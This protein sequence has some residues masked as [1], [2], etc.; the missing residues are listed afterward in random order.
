LF[1][2]LGKRKAFTAGWPGDEVGGD[3]AQK[4]NE[5]DVGEA[6]TQAATVN[7]VSVKS[8]EY[9]MSGSRAVHTMSL[10]CVN[11]NGRGS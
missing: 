4:R 7:V 8:G 3:S 11:P 9:P 5:N 10:T 6:A 1:R 2:S